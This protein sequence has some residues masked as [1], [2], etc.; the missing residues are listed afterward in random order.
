MNKGTPADSVVAA[1]TEPP[2]PEESQSLRDTFR[3]MVQ[4]L[5]EYRW[6]QAESAKRRA[7]SAREKD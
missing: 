3:E 5:V 6:Q 7:H 2:P 4:E 1:H